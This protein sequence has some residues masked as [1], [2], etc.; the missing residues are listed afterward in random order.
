MCMPEVI[1]ETIQS[2]YI[3]PSPLEGTFPLDGHGLYLIIR[4]CLTVRVASSPI[5]LFRFCVE[6]SQYIWTL[7]MT[8]GILYFV[9]IFSII[10]IEQNLKYL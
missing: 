6:K 5:A 9:I 1:S 8:D 7:R 2:I 3:I 10:Y 4:R